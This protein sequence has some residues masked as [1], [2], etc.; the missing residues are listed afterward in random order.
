MT[1]GRTDGRAIAYT[2]YSIYAVARKNDLHISIPSDLDLWPFDLKLVPLVNLIIQRYIFTKLGVS[3]A[4]CF[5][6]I[7]G[8]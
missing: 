2:R 8:T 7:V 1:D 6:K 3:T 4:I 5:E